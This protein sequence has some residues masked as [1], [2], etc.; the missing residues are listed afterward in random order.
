MPLCLFIQGQRD[1]GLGGR[2]GRN[3]SKRKKKGG[4]KSAT[5]WCCPLTECLRKKNA[6]VFHSSHPSQNH[7]SD[8]GGIAVTAVTLRSVINPIRVQQGS[9]ITSA[10]GVGGRREEYY[11]G[12]GTEPWWHFKKKTNKSKSLVTVFGVACDC[13]FDR[14]VLYLSFPRNWSDC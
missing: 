3:R 2:G 13:E 5:M 10:G 8:S 1:L 12:V 7:R 9:V 6:R 4:G 14:S 11:I